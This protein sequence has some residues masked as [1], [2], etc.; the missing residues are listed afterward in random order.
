MEEYRLYHYIVDN[1]KFGYVYLIEGTHKGV[2]RYKIGKANS[3]KERLSRFEVKI[4]FDVDLFFSF[5]VKNALAFEA[6]LHRHFS[7]KRLSGEWFDLSISDLQ[8]LLIL[9]MSKETHD[10]NSELTSFIEQRRAERKRSKWVN[11]REYIRYL[12]S[13]LVFNKIEFENRV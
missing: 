8:E 6:E 4:P 5:R 1:A 3:I 11:D 7:K 2:S 10:Y 12:E 9:G 13:V